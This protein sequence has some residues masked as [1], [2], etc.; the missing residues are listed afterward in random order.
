MRIEPLGR[1]HNRLDFDCGNLQLNDYLKHYASQDVKRRQSS[2]YVLTEGDSG[3]IIGF[4]TLC[5]HVVDAQMLA[6]DK[7]GRRK[8]IP[9]FLLGRLAFGG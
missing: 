3:C 8:F 7:V 6:D 5:A 1:Q 4:Y 9:A 2:C